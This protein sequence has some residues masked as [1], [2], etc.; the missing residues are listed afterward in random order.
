ME[1]IILSEYSKM[2]FSVAD[3]ITE[4][5]LSSVKMFLIVDD[6]I[7]QREQDKI[8]NGIDLITYLHLRKKITKENLQFL[9]DVLE[10][11]HRCDL[12]SMIRT[13]EQARRRPVPQDPKPISTLGQRLLCSQQLTGIEPK[14]FNNIQP[15]SALFT[16]GNNRGTEFENEGQELPSSQ[17]SNCSDEEKLNITPNKLKSMMDWDTNTGF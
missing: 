9:K 2:L 5:D 15:E 14:K 3:Q 1:P 12:V 16:T 11:I 6:L 10:E 17:E 8:K 13:Y 7:C 4:N